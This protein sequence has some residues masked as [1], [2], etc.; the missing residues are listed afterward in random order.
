MFDAE[1]VFANMLRLD[2]KVKLRWIVPGVDNPEEYVARFLFYVSFL[3]MWRCV[4]QN[5]T[6]GINSAARVASACEFEPCQDTPRGPF[7]ESPVRF[8]G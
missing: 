1:R 2:R 5:V 8:D 3:M 6:A 4:A 7:G